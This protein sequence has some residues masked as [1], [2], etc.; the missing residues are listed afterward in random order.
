MI[1]DDQHAGGGCHAAEIHGGCGLRKYD[2]RNMAGTGTIVLL[3]MFPGLM[4][5]VPM[6]GL[7]TARRSNGNTDFLF[8]F[9][10]PPFADR[11]HPVSPADGAGL[12][13]QDDQKQTKQ[14]HR[15]V[16]LKS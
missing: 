3:V 12:H 9:G 11:R 15:I 5:I 7:R 8:R 4:E 2:F 6:T 14:F 10:M 13:Y 16:S 1:L